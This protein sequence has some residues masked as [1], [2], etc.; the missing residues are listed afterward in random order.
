MFDSIFK[1][2]PD[3]FFG[4]FMIMCGVALVAGV[5]FSFIASF[6]VRSNKRFFVI[7]AIL[8]TVI[9]IIASLT[10]SYA[11]WGAAIAVSGAFGLIRFRS[12]QGSAEEIGV[13]AIE[14][15]AGFAFGLGYL[16]IG[17]LILIA[18][19]LVFFLL[20]RLNIFE[21]K[22][23]N[24]DKLLR[25]TIPESL[26]Y[27]HTFDEEFS[28]FC[29]SSR[30]IRAKTINMGSMYRLEYEVTLK[31]SDLEKPFM[32]AIRVKNGNL[33]VYMTEAVR[34]QGEL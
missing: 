5:L 21:H 13:L 12:A 28:Q 9:A 18:L 4:A 14:L 10:S 26:D 3:Q 24:R 32:D 7:T 34:I 22:G 27:G 20:S 19:G 31:N 30:L 2:L 6:R 23:Q 16:T 15:A 17:A 1:L 8:P 25:I 29:S 33:E 11:Y